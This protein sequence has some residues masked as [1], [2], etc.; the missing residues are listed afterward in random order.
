MLCLHVQIKVPSFQ[1]RCN[2]TADVFHFSARLAEVILFGGI[3]VYPKNP[4]FNA[5][6]SMIAQTTVLRFG[7][8]DL[9]D[10][11]HTIL[12]SSIIINTIIGTG[13]H[14]HFHVLCILTSQ[15]NFLYVQWGPLN[16]MGMNCSSSNVFSH[17]IFEM[18][19]IF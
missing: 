4:K 17:K 13:G 14:N 16:C 2:H 3:P 15:V 18:Y 11:S 5:D 9:T 6:F 8:C 12:H 7:E 1:S 10:A 19:G